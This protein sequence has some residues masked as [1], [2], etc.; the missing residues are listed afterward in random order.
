MRRM[1]LVHTLPRVETQPS[2]A[3]AAGMADPPPL[4]RQGH[5]YGLSNVQM[6]QLKAS[7]R[8]SLSLTPPS[9]KQKSKH[10][11]H[12]KRILL[13]SLQQRPVSIPTQE[14]ILPVLEISAKETSH[15]ETT[16]EQERVCPPSPVTTPSGT[17]AAPAG[18]VPPEGNFLG[19]ASGAPYSNS[20]DKVARSS[21]GAV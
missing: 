10:L 13:R 19:P 9:P 8:H 16:W 4:T 1:D 11:Q 5:L 6:G 3:G 2:K 7:Y 21:F 17:R 14:H 20:A 15:D 18:H 12:P